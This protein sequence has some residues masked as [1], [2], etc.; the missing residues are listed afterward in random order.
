MINS[1]N[2]FHCMAQEAEGI[3][4]CD[5]GYSDGAEKRLNYSCY[6]PQM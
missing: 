6:L 5:L 2:Y 1:F 3:I 4:T